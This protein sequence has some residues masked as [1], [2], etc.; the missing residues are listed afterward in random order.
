MSDYHGQL[1]HV[2]EVL[3]QLGKKREDLAVRIQELE[4][5][6][7]TDAR[8]Y[9]RKRKGKASYLYLVPPMVDGVRPKQ[10]YIG[11][12]PEKQQ[13]ALARVE[14]FEQHQALQRDLAALEEQ[15]ARVKWRVADLGHLAESACAATGTARRRK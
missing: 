1:N 9:W 6:G 4:A 13:E 7:I 15:I 3:D 12:D 10:E 5:A 14:R 11:A 2:A 8:P